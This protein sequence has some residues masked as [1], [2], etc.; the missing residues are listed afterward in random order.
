MAYH[1]PQELP[2]EAVGHPAGQRDRPA[3]A[4]DAQQL[5]GR[6]FLIGANMTPTTEMTASNEGSSNGSASASPLTKRTSRLSA[7]AR[8]PNRTSARDRRAARRTAREATRAR[9]PAT[10]ARRD[11]ENHS[12][13]SGW[14]C[15]CHAHDPCGDAA[16][17]R[18]EERNSLAPV[19]LRV[20]WSLRL[21]LR[22][23]I[24]ARERFYADTRSARR[25]NAPLRQTGSTAGPVPY[26]RCVGQASGDRQ[27]RCCIVRQS[28]TGVDLLGL[29]PRNSTRVDFLGI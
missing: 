13:P 9:R 6:A 7:A 22:P 2:G 28:S 16:G 26:Q 24:S 20:G 1:Q 15:G 21:A 3:R 8:H 17:A 5:G 19:R 10:G 11:G 23:T 29:R 27:P 14:S 25:G 4:A 12:E 18:N